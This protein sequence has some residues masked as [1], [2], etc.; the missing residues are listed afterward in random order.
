MDKDGFGR[1]RKRCY[2]HGEAEY[3]AHSPALL[4]FLYYIPLEGL[5]VTRKK[6]HG[7][8]GLKGTM[9]RNHVRLSWR[10]TTAETDS[11]DEQHAGSLTR[12]NDDVHQLPSVLYLC[13]A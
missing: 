12:L 5:R 4:Y 7:A 6:D 10:P 9:K 13:R 1:H 3:K 8:G 11:M 2:V